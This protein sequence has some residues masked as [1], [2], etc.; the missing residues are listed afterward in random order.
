M[1]NIG[2]TCLLITIALAW[3]LPVGAQVYNFHTYRELDGLPSNTV[4]G[5]VHE[6]Q[7]AE[8]AVADDGDGEQRRQALAV[9]LAVVQPGGAQRFTLVVVDRDLRRH[10]ERV[11]RL[12]ATGEERGSVLVSRNSA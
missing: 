5:I 10:L 2:R 11:I 1:G 3:A 8:L 4:R 12:G 9:S 6:D 7:Q